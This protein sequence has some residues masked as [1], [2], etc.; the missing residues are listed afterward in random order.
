[1]TLGATELRAH[2]SGHGEELATLGLRLAV[3]SGSAARVLAAAERRRAAGLLL[4]PARPPDDAELAAELAGAA[5]RHRRARRVAA[6]GPPGRRASSAARPRSSARSAAAPCARARRDGRRRD[7]ARRSGCRRSPPL[8][9]A[10]GE[11]ALVEFVALDGRLL[12]VTVADGRARLHALGADAATSSARSR[13]C[14]SACAASRPRGPG[15]A[16]RRRWP[17]S[18]RRSRARLDAL[19]FAPLELARAA[20]R[21]RADRRAARAAVVDAARASRTRPLAVAPSL[22][23][24]HRAATRAAAGRRAAVLVAGPRLPAADARRS[25][26]SPHATRRRPRSPATTRRSPTSRDALDGADSAH[27]AAHGRFRDDNPLFT[28]PRA[29]RRRASRSTTSSACARVAAPDRALELR[30][31]P[32]RRPRGRRADGLHRGGLRARHADRDRRRRARPGRGD[33]RA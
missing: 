14:G 15:R 20:A 10:L 13:R 11:R 12:A 25:R 8:A 22:R 32:L 26:R 21:A 1:M 7:A 33:R 23:L 9:A 24:W 27:V 18:A 6:R 17:T 5:A 4:R 19:L 3:E 2:A 29:R 31:R 16:R 28:Q 30:V